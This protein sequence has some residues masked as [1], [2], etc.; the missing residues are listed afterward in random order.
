MNAQQDYPLGYS[1]REAKR[2]A[3]Q[4][5]MLEELTADV[6][7]RA[8]LRPGMNVL[9]LGCGVG[10]VSLLAA[11]IVGASGSVLGVDR[12]ASSLQT[13]ARRAASAGVSNARFAEA[14]LATFEPQQSFDAIVGRLVLLYLPDAPATLRR[15]SRALR[16]GGIV[17]FQEYDM[18]PVSQIPAGELFMRVR[19]W[20]LAAFTAAG[21][22]LDMGTKLYSTF[23][24]AGLPPPG[25]TSA[26]PVA[27]G[28]SSPGYENVAGVVRSLLPLI[29]RKGIATAAEVDIDTLADR[30]RE[31][32][33]AH[34]RVT[35]MPRVVGAW[36]Q[37][38]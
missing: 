11:R 32:S 23:L 26:T 12:A 6:F 22:E 37:T 24:R 35:F 14:D 13:A 30:L 34:E 31:D 9:D 38:V 19:E 3:S 33:L 15:L 5:A 17:A 4:A 18:S 27:C 28:P 36:T 16:P 20:L 29:E 2:L 8:G 21:A 25:M 7:R 1:D 10:D